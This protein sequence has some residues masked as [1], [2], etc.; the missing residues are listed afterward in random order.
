MKTAHTLPP[1]DEHTRRH[2]RRQRIDHSAGGVIYR[3]NERG[4]VEAALISTRGGTRW[5][6]PKGTCESGETVEETALREV[7]EECGLT[8]KCEAHLGVIEY[9]YWDTHQRAV[10]ELVRKRVD[11]YLMR[12]VGGELNDASIEVDGVNWFPLEQ[13]LAALTYPSEREILQRAMD[14]LET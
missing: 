10:P 1:I 12:A 3:I 2:W 4:A 8:G 5:Q 9:W 6:L 14:R 13:A 7:A 11:F